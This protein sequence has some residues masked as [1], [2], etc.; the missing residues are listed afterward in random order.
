MLKNNRNNHFLG[1]ALRSLLIKKT[2]FKKNQQGVTL[3]IK[4]WTL[5]L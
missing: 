1:L 3:T 5:T 2:S 4:F